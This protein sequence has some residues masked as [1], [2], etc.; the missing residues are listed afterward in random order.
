MMRRQ[1]CAERS[2]KKITA[3]TFTDGTTGSVFPYDNIHKWALDEFGPLWI[4]K[5]EV[6]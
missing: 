6:R 1:K 4:P 2:C 5:K 3:E